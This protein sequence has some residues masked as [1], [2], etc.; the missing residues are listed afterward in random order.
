MRDRFNQKRNKGRANPSHKHDLPSREQLKQLVINNGCK[1]PVTG[2]VCH[3]SAGGLK[4]W[5]VTLDHIVPVSTAPPGMNPWRIS[6]IQVMSHLMNHIKGN[7]PDVE[8][9]R[10]FSIWKCANM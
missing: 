10:W 8:I 9:H 7:H 4:S 6:N 2:F 3:W 5:S 1:C